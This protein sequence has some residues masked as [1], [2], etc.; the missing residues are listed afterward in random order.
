MF[1]GVQG[2]RQAGLGGQ[3]SGPHAAADHDCPGANGAFV[4]HHTRSA[5]MLHKDLR[6]AGVFEN[7]RSSHAGALGVG[8]GDVCG[9]DLAIL[10]E[11][12]AANDALGADG[13]HQRSLISA[14]AHGFHRQTEIA[15]HGGAARQLLVAG[16]RVGKHAANLAV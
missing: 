13:G 4:R 9:I 15:A 6:D 10:R 1:G 7:A 2:E 8:H 12:E 14:G 11:P 5:V 16:G 3:V